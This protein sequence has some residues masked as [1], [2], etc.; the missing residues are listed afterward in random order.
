MVFQ[1]H[2]EASFL[3]IEIHTKT[4][5]L[6]NIVHK[7]FTL[8]ME[9]ILHLPCLSV[10]LFWPVS[11]TNISV[12][13]FPDWTEWLHILSVVWQIWQMCFGI[14]R[15]FQ[16]VESTEFVSVLLFSSF[17][18]QNYFMFSQQH[19]SYELHWWVLFQ[20]AKCKLPVYQY[21]T[22]IL[23]KIFKKL[24]LGIGY[25]GTQSFPHRNQLKL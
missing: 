23:V 2:N 1:V 12:T 25:S 7:I 16:Y 5:N 24:L 18:D 4:L 11:P 8:E 13:L 22:C 21:Y 17:I 19:G 15:I 14:H 3:K 20:F 9:A 10:H 6:Q